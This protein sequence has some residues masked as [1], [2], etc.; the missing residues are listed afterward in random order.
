MKKFTNLI[1][2]IAIIISNIS[3]LQAE[4]SITKDYLEKQNFNEIQKKK[5]L[6]V[7]WLFVFY[8]NALWEWLPNSYK[9]INLKFKNITP[10]TQIYDALQKWVYMDL[11]KNKE[12]NLSLEK[13]ATQEL[14]AKMVM[15][16]FGEEMSFTAKTPLTL[17]DFLDVMNDLKELSIKEEEESRYPFE[18]NKIPNFNILND[19]YIKIKNSHY[20]SENFIDEKLL[21]WAMKWI[22]EATEDKYTTYFP[23]VEAKN[24]SDELS[25]EFE[26]IWSHVEMEKPWILHIVAPINGSP[27]QKAWLKPGD[28]V[29]KID[30]FEVNET[31]SL[32]QAVNKI[33]WKAGTQVNLIILRNWE[34]LIITVTRAKITI[35]YVEYSRLDN[36]N[37]YIKI[38]TF[39]IGTFR[40]FSWVVWQI[41]KENPD[42][43]IIL[44]LRNNPG[45]SLDEVA[46]MLEYFVP[47][48]E[49]VVQIKYK[50]I[51]VNMNAIWYANNELKDKKIIILI[52]K[53][54]ASA[55]EIMAWTIKDYF[56]WNAIIIGETSYWKGSVQS[57]YDYSDGSSFKYT[58]AKWL[59][60]KT[61]TSIDW[62][63]IKPD[64]E[65][66][67]DEEKIKNWTDN[68]LDFAKNYIF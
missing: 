9:Y 2:F 43:K 36:W 31:V 56:N 46:A 6:T 4:E 51:A 30:D 32:Q 54:S 8:F 67:L 64:I 11:I 57:I 60:G 68:Q 24:F 59:T 20:N 58:I 29:I 66:K 49:S 28:Q 23:P 22:A 21:Q 50:N 48:W 37:N 26:W 12:I 17:K 45:W 47:R 10:E 63:G 33:K 7:K 1:L 27:A 25:W 35:P 3:Y 16:N 40:A 62:I 55:S 34:T 18:I 52:N 39:W 5:T 15:E 42:G 41:I 13:N 53:W 65:I 19:M 61:K 38:S 44:D 14:F